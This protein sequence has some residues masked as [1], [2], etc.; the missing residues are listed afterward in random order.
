MRDCRPSTRSETRL[1]GS[2]HW[3]ATSAQRRAIQ[4][5][6]AR[7]EPGWRMT[8]LLPSPDVSAMP[9]AALAFAVARQSRDEFHCEAIMHPERR[10]QGEVMID[11]VDEPHL[12]GHEL[13]VTE[14]PQRLAP[15]GVVGD[16]FPRA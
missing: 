4:N 10:E 6:S 14:L 13:V 2:R 16:P 8:K 7:A 15:D 9:A 5:F 1:P 11:R 3:S 12:R